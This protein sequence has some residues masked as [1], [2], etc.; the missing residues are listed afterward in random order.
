MIRVR[1]IAAQSILSG[2]MLALA[3]CGSSEIPQRDDAQAVIWRAGPHL[4]QPVTNNAV[5]AVEIAGETS[6]F[7]FLGMDSTKTWRGVTNAA[8]RWDVDTDSGWR[9]IEPVPGPGRLA[10]TARVVDGRVYVFGGY[11]VAQDGTERSLAN[12]DIYDPM[13]G[14]WSRGADM[15]IAVDDAA[16]GV[17]RDSLIVIVSG[18]H[19][20]GNVAAVQWYDP[21]RDRWTQANQ[22]TGAP[23]FGHNGTVVQDQVVY[24][25]GVRETGEA[26]RFVINHEDW[27]GTIDPDDAR[28]IDW[29]PAPDHPEPSIYRAASG[30]LGALALFVG[31]TANPYNYDGIGYDGTPAE[32]LRQVMAYAPRA[33]FWRNLYAPP[34]ASMDHRTLG[35]AG[36]NVFL[37]GGMEEGQRVTDKVWYADVEKLLA[38]IW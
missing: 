14:A 38:S 32:P 34:I 24:I 20:D 30:T 9:E 16:S 37:V 23:V 19:D 26:S 4:P 10:S 12:V 6:V 18:W 11:T 36:G 22:V 28:R 21:A 33:G 31:G 35:V 1:G 15:P 25:D 29:Q 7:S 3:G 27:V 8:Y 17:W 5:V 13:T 2:A